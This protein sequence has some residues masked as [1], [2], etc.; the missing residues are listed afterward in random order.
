MEKTMRGGKKKM[1]ENDVIK[2]WMDRNSG[3]ILKCKSS[4][5]PNKLNP[6]YICNCDWVEVFLA[7]KE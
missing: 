4:E 7:T 3:I 6:G 1:I 5:L 2:C